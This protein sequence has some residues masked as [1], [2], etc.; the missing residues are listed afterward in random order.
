MK[1]M[2]FL[3]RR[4]DL[5]R[6]A[7]QA[8]WLDEHRPLAEA[9]PGLIEHRFNL[10]PEGAPFDAIVEQWFA[11]REA[12]ESCYATPQGRA[13]SADS[14]RRLKGR[15]RILVEEHAFPRMGR[16]DSV[17]SAAEK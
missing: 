2:I 10:L 13:V 16:V 7:F 14:A 1:A 12:A 17:S 11:S 6:A 4:D 5:S 3:S 9:L 8:W 15:L